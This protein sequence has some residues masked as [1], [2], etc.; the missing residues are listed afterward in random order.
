MTKRRLCYTRTQ[1]EERSKTLT[2]TKEEICK[3]APENLKPE[4]MSIQDQNNRKFGTPPRT[5]GQTGH[6]GGPWEVVVIGRIPSAGG[7]LSNTG[8][9][10]L[11]GTRD[12]L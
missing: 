7:E 3:R 2:E 5:L 6:K 10:P 4:N 1:R 12:F 9:S 11:V 8:S